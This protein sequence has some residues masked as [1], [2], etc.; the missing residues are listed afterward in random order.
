ML[1]VFDTNPVDRLIIDLRNNPGGNSAVI[2][3]FLTGL[4]AR[5][6]RFAS[7]TKKMVI[8]GRRTASSALLNAISLKGQPYTILVGEPT[9]GR[10]NSYGETLN[11]TLPNT[12]ATSV[13][14]PSI[15]R[16]RS[17]RIP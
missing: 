1:G 3:P 12:G 11:L 7:G 6:S 13:I 4:Q 2:D 16:R 9:G 5:Q 17:R 14:P 8:I 15:S 10:P